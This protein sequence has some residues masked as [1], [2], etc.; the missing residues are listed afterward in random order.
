MSNE[1]GPDFGTLTV[2]VIEEA[3]QRSIE[4]CDREISQI[5]ALKNAERTF[6]NTIEALESAQDL[7][8]QAA[9]QYGFMAYVAENQDI[10]S[11]ARDW[12]AK[13]EQ[14]LLD[15]SFREDIYRVVQEYEKI[16]EALN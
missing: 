6:A 5:V 4:L 9:G 16:N 13:L 10:R 12:E 8:G 7:I 15:L 1:W 2:S 14:Y 11:I 3:C